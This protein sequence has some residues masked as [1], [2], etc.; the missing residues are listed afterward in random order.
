MATS[1]KYKVDINLSQN[2][3]LNAVLHSSATA[4]TTPVAGQIYYNSTENRI[5]HYDGTAWQQVA[6]KSYVDSLVAGGGELVGSFDASGGLLPTTGSGTAG[7]IVKGDRW[8]ITVA[9][10]IAGLGVLEVGDLLYAGTDSASVAGDFFVVQGNL[11][12]A[13][14]TVRGTAKIATQVLVDAE[15][16]DTD[17][18]TALKLA[19][20][21]QNKDFVK[22]YDTVVLLGT[23]EGVTTI[24][25]NLNTK[26]VIV[27]VLDA[28]DESVVIW[29][30]A[31]TVNTIQVE[32]KGASENHTITVHAKA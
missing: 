22:S 7:A 19:T 14:E 24:T 3:L 18:V 21:L 4:P 23:T 5:Y 11:D 28:N 20:Y 13:T 29:W 30:K 16:N 2:Q 31:N 27:E 6:V 26:S 12:Q 25:H 9:G 10:T 15:V 8:I 17:I 1:R 32:A